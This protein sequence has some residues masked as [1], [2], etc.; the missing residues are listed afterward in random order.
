MKCSTYSLALRLRF[1]L[2]GMGKHCPVRRFV[3]LMLAVISLASV[4]ALAHSTEEVLL[5]VTQT[6]DTAKQVARTVS[7]LLAPESD[8]KRH[9]L[10][11]K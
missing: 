4:V 10:C 5:P 1:G 11:A 2:F 8:W 6:P 9:I 3:L 7:Q